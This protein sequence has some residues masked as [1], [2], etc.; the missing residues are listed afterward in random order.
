MIETDTSSLTQL[1]KDVVA[2]TTPEEAVL[3]RVPNGN[4]GTLTPE[5]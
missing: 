1:G 3:E 5:R 4:T 2:P